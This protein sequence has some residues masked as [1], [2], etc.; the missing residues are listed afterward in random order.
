MKELRRVRQSG[1]PVRQEDLG[2]ITSSLEK[3]TAAMSSL[4]VSSPLMGE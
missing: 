4:S 2:S 1:A 3:I